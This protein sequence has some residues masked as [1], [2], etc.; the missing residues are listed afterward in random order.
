M[1]MSSRV[2]SLFGFAFVCGL[3]G[4][5]KWIGVNLGTRVFNVVLQLELIRI[6]PLPQNHYLYYA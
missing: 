2:Y 5:W 1:T 6:Q 4:R 3:L